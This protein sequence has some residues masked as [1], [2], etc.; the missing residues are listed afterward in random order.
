[1]TL[2]LVTDNPTVEI[3]NISTIADAARKFA[4]ELDAGEHGDVT[5]VTVLIETVGTLSRETW[6]EVPTGYELVGM[7][8]VAKLGV[9]DDD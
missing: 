6:G 9:L 7:L 5:S 2:K 8:E 1:M 3:S 4:D